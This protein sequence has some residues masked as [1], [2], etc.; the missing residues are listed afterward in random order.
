M[1]KLKILKW[2]V[3]IVLFLA[4][5][6]IGAY[7]CINFVINTIKEKIPPE[8]IKYYATNISEESDEY[9]DS[10]FQIIEVN[11]NSTPVLL[12]KYD[13]GTLICKYDEEVSECYRAAYVSSLRILYN[14]EEEKYQLF[15]YGK[16]Y[17]YDIYV[18]LEN[19]YIYHVDSEGRIASTND[20]FSDKYLNVTYVSDWVKLNSSYFDN[21]KKLISILM[22]EKNKNKTINTYLTDSMKENIDKK[23]DKEEKSSKTVPINY[24]ITGNLPN[25]KSIKSCE[26]E[27][28]EVEI[29]GNKDDI[30]SIESINIKFDVS[31][32]TKNSKITVKIDKPSGVKSLS[33][34]TVTVLLTLTDSIKTKTFNVPIS[35]TNLNSNLIVSLSNSSKTN[36]E[37]TVMGSEE[38]LNSINDSD[39]N[40]YIDLSGYNVGEYEVPIKVKINNEFVTYKIDQQTIKVNISNH[41]PLGD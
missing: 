6:V 23:L 28:E 4:L 3:I 35:V 34:D 41:K 14:I 7:F 27:I 2:T 13:D 9:Y 22:E 39:I 40:A 25:G 36:A 12:L 10:E 16:G 11:E 26:L 32:I 37:V 29:Y 31:N 24:T 8:W 5:L 20:K 33:K 1:K 17:Y 21:N 18:N 30:E 19:D 15:L 38:V